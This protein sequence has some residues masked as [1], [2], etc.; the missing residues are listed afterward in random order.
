MYDFNAWN[1]FFFQVNSSYYIWIWIEWMNEWNILFI[2]GKTLNAITYEDNCDSG[3]WPSEIDSAAKGNSLEVIH[4]K[5]K[6]TYLT[7]QERLPKNLL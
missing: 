7:H 2:D 1:D 4:E 3:K 6:K 5:I